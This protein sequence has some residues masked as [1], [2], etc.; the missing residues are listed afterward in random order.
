VPDFT[1][2]ADVSNTLVAVLSDALKVLDPPGMDTAPQAMLHDLHEPP[3]PAAN[4]AGVLAVTLVEA[5]EDGSSRN[6]PRVRTK[7]PIN[8]DRVNQ[9]KPPMA[10]QLR[11]LFTPWGKENNAEARTVEHKMLGRVAQVLYDDAII[12]GPKLQGQSLDG[13]MEALKITLAPLSFEEQTRFWHAVSQ[14]YRVSLTYD[15]RVVN[16]DPI[17]TTSSARVSSRENQYELIEKP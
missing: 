5:R 4:Q 15:V 9:A 13:S 12:A 10:L 8:S 1:V 14:K 7:D 11:Y 2:I 17:R 3:K 16:L 6:R